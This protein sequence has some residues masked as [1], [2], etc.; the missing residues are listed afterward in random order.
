M[1]ATFG[2]LNINSR[3]QVAEGLMATGWVPQ[4]F[5]P[6][7]DPQVNK[8]VLETLAPTNP[9]AAAVLKARRGSKWATAYAIP[10]S[11]V[12]ENG[13]IHPSIN[14]L[15]ARTARMSVSN[16]P[17]QQLPSGDRTIR[18]AVIP[19]DGRVLWAADYSQVE[20][21][22]LAAL[23]NER[24]M[25]DSIANG[26]DLHDATAQAIFGDDFTKDHRKIAKATNFLIVYGGGQAALARNAGI[27]VH[28]AKD[29]IDRYRR[30]F[31]AIGRYSRRLQER[32]EGGRRLVITASG[33]QLPVDGD[34][35][36]SAVNFV[37]QSSARDVLAQALLAMVDAGLRPGDDLLLPIHDECI[38]QVEPDRFAEVSEV[39]RDAMSMDFL[40]VR[41]DAAAE[42][43]GERWGDGYA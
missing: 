24:N 18:D 13:Y 26:I 10:M 40:G 19:D 41:L 38:G 32:A 35:L 5:T 3:N 14:T 21:R 12:D 15:Q 31:P 28:E 39:I 30:Q 16:P 1:A 23:A 29:A 25:K 33:R 37:V 8:A 7:G 36:Y 42:V 20:L 17:L 9:L 22:V 43:L 6:G 2:V 27:T 4:H 11:E 34:R